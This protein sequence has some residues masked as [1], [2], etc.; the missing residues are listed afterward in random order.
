M[1]RRGNWLAN[2]G[3]RFADYDSAINQALTNRHV[4]WMHAVSVGEVE[5]CTQLIRALEPH[6][7][8]AKIVVSCT[9]TTG[10]GL[11]RKRLPPHI[12]KIYYPVDRRKFV[13]RAIA[14][15]NPQAIILL[16][17][18]IWPKIGRASCRERV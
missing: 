10:M 3:Q 6:V 2:F 11:Y 17:A 18:E 14:T 15:I 13:R 1:T 4:I 9:T 12:T 8:N 16:E 5:M 7:P